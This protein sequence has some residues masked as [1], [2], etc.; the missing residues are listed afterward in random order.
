MCIRDSPN[1]GPN[2]VFLA[3]I[4]GAFSRRNYF[5]MMHIVEHIEYLVNCLENRL[6]FPVYEADEFL[7]LIMTRDTLV[8]NGTDLCVRL[9]ACAFIFS[10]K[11]VETLALQI[12]KKMLENYDN[13]AI[14]MM[15]KI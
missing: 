11:S 7:V 8:Q 1:L 14:L 10:S 6:L 9:L 5:L 3:L 13:R 2:R 12:F 15:D 4:G